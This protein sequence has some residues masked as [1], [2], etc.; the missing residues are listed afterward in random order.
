[1]KESTETN[2]DK[3]IANIRDKDSKNTSYAI[4]NKGLFES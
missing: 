4:Q 1:M 2:I 3:F